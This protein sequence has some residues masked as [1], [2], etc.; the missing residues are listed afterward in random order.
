M[1]EQTYFKK[2][3]KNKEKVRAWYKSHKKFRKL[4]LWC[5]EEENPSGDI[6]KEIME[7]QLYESQFDTKLKRSIW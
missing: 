7:E 3:M 5:Y 4:K 6:W 1:S 2:Y